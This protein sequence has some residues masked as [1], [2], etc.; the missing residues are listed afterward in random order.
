MDRMQPLRRGSH[1]VRWQMLGHAD[2]QALR[3]L[4]GDQGAAR[5]GAQQDLVALQQPAD[6]RQVSRRRTEARA[7]VAP[8]DPIGLLI[9]AALASPEFR[10]TDGVIQRVFGRSAVRPHAPGDAGPVARAGVPA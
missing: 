5:L 6:R 3:G 2:L 10:L 1:A 7:A 8:A 9:R 4:P